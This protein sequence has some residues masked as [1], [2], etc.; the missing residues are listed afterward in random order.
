MKKGNEWHGGSDTLI[1]QEY[2]ET[3]KRS[4]Q[5]SRDFLKTVT[6]EELKVL[7]EEEG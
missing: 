2:T 1:G 3:M 7:A 5:S 6:P 4:L